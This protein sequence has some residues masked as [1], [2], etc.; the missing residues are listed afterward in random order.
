MG[1]YF[2]WRVERSGDGWSDD[3]ERHLPL[4]PK[5]PSQA[6]GASAP[7][8]LPEAF[9]DWLLDMANLGGVTVSVGTLKR[10]ESTP[11]ANWLRSL[12]VTLEF[13]GE[14][15]LFFV[16]GDEETK[17]L[18]PEYLERFLVLLA[19]DSFTDTEEIPAYQALALL[20]YII[21]TERYAFHEETEE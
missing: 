19:S 20:T 16:P 2:Y 12:N 4:P 8:L 6:P 14:H 3:Q 18:L 13:K 11:V 21:T 9:Q 1:G 10:V 7:S 5:A 15:Y 17:A